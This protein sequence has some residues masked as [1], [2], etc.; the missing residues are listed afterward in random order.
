MKT[1]IM[2][3]SGRRLWLVA[4][5]FAALLAFVAL[6]READADT[7]RRSGDDIHPVLGWIVNEQFAPIECGVPVT[8]NIELNVERFNLGFLDSVGS[9]GNNGVV[10][11]SNAAPANAD[12]GVAYPGG[13][14]VT[15]PDDWVT[16]PNGTLSDTVIATV[17]VTPTTPGLHVEVLAFLGSGVS[18]AGGALVVPNFFVPIP[19]LVGVTWYA[20]DCD[21][22]P[23][24]AD[25]QLT[26]VKDESHDPA[27]AGGTDLVHTVTVGGPCFP[28]LR[29]CHQGQGRYDPDSAPCDVRRY[30]RAGQ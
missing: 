28:R 11:F 2:P 30:R 15:L 7:A 23:P 16:Q 12:V 26:I 3:D 18:Q 25:V 4:I 14:S 24:L 20:D 6:P 9:F 27:I 1:L 5:V 22:D 10:T 21:P 19:M 8:T 13:P 29:Q 17:T